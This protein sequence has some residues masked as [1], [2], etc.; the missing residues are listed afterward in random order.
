MSKCYISVIYQKNV[1]LYIP[2]PCWN[3]EKILEE[4]SSLNSIEYHINSDND[5]VITDL[6]F[7]QKEPLANQQYI[8]IQTLFG[9]LFIPLV[10]NSKDEDDIKE[11]MLCLS[12]SNQYSKKL[13]E[14]TLSI[15]Y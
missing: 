5:I 9:K 10:V 8:T 15:D 13:N 7:S 6:T 4:F 14:N 3:R 1:I 11:S 12:Y 2:L